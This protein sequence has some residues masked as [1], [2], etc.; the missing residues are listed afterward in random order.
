MSTAPFIPDPANV[1]RDAGARWQRLICDGGIAMATV[2][3]ED[4]AHLDGAF[5]GCAGNVEGQS[6]ACVTPDGRAEH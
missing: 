6:G 1:R 4:N 5:T 3:A 2:V